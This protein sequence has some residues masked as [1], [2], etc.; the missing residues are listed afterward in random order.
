MQVDGEAGDENRQVKIDAGEAGQ[1]KRNAKE[2]EVVH[3]EIMRAR[4]GK[5]RG[6]AALF[7]PDEEDFQDEKILLIQ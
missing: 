4:E 6:F 7:Q 5:S 2:L 3:G 1:A